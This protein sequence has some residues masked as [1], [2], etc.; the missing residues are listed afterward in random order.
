MRISAHEPAPAKARVLGRVYRVDCFQDDVVMSDATHAGGLSLRSPRR[1]RSAEERRMIVE[2]TLE[3]ES[4]VAR[5]AMQHGID[6]N[7]VFECG[8]CIRPPS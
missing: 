2:E 5:V 8:A 1:R 3:A 7:Q 6:A 4:S